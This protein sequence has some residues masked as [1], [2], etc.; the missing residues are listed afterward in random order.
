[1]TSV[2]LSCQMSSVIRSDE[3]HIYSASTVAIFWPK[4]IEGGAFRIPHRGS[5]CGIPHQGFY[6]RCVE[7]SHTKDFHPKVARCGILTAGVGSSSWVTMDSLLLLLLRLLLRLLLLLLL[8][9]L[10]R[11][12]LFL[13][14]RLL[15]LLLWLFAFAFAVAFAFAFCF[16]LVLLLLLSI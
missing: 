11:F 8:P 7:A 15:L 9:V 1:M 3:L 13:L 14:L 10:L 16:L 4:K 5:W 2:K 6:P 12:R